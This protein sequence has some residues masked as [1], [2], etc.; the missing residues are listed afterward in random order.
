MEMTKT[1]ATAPEAPPTTDDINDDIPIE[2]VGSEES[3]SAAECTLR[4]WRFTKQKMTEQPSES[5]AMRTLDASDGVLWVDLGQ[6][7]ETDL[8]ELMDRF[9]L[10]P[11]GIRAALAPWQ[12]P[13]V[14]AFANHALVN[15]TVLDIDLDRLA[16]VANEIDC[17]IGERFVLTAHPEELPFFDQILARAETNAEVISTDPAFLL[18]ILLD[19]LIDDFAGLADELDELIEDLEVEALAANDSAFVD[20]LVRHK[21]FVYTV[22]RLAG[23]HRFVFHGLLRPD[24]PFVS[25]GSVEGYFAELNDRFGTVAGLFDQARQEMLSTFDIYMS[26]VAYRTNGIMKTLTMISILVLPATAIFGFFGT[27][28]AHMP[29]FGTVGFIAMFLLLLVLTTAQLLLFRARG[30]LS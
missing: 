20:R 22:S 2:L 7:G 12:R 28:F 1:R 29:I 21:R 26:S 15:V 23:Q 9:E 8:Q 10:D 30:W 19:E 24:F 16:I 5:K 17:F 25:G 11:A 6:Y 3:D 27:N 14:E 13:S 18:Y 4:A